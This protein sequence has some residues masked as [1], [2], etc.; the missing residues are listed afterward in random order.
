M[1]R[2]EAKR[3]SVEDVVKRRRRKGHDVCFFSTS[4]CPLYSKCR[5]I[6]KKKEERVNLRNIK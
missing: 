2:K 4:C 6:F 5:R 1:E 3:E